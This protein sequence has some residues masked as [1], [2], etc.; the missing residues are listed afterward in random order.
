MHGTLFVVSGV[1]DTGLVSTGWSRGL[2][3]AGLPH[4]IETFTWQQRRWWSYLT[5]ADLWR[6]Q[7]HHRQ[8]EELADRIRAARATGPVHVFAHSA[9]TAIT[10]YAL[11]RL[12]PDE[13]VC[14]AVFVASGLSSRFDL[15]PA[16]NRC[17]A[18]ILSVECATDFLTLGIGTSILGTCDRRWRPAAGLLGFRAPAHELAYRK[19]HT[20]RW[21]LRHL[22]AGWIGGHI[23]SAVP[24][25]AR[26]VLADW[27]RRAESLCPKP[28]AT[29]T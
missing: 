10:A 14:S 19:L 24:G 17:D 25:F 18:G 29:L 13:T 4:V 15:T 22:K 26:T 21:S 2:R 7:Y 12:A 8:A 11:A 16:L 3:S 20:L 5:Y 6:V 23:F 1:N 28:A 9:G 27:V